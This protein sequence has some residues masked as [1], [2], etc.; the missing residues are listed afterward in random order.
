MTLNAEIP[1]DG[2]LHLEIRDAKGNIFAS[3]DLSDFDAIQ[4]TV[5]EKLPEGPFTIHAR[6][7]KARL[8]TLGFTF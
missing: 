7:R 1:K 4:A 6:M 3:R 2:Y 8:Y 5:F